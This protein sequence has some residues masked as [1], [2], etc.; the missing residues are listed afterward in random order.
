M[1]LT[2]KIVAALDE[3]L[4]L[5][6]RRQPP[7]A[8]ISPSA[9]G[10]ECDRMVS[11]EYFEAIEEKAK[12]KRQGEAYLAPRKFDPHM[13]RVFRDGSTLETMILD[14]LERAGFKLDRYDSEGKQHGFRAKFGNKTFSGRVDAI[15]V[16]SPFEEVATPAI[17]DVKTMNDDKWQKMVKHGLAKSH[18]QYVAQLQLYMGMMGLTNPA[19]LVAYNK[20][21]AQYAIEFVPFDQ[22][23]CQELIQRAQRLLDASSPYDLPRGGLSREMPPCT[24]CRFADKCWTPMLEERLDQVVPN[25]IKKK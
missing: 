14:D 23:K 4:D 19:M 9:L 20:N 12:A 15:I 11:F 22:E 24:W 1:T 5:E 21:T 10:G 16:R 17:V 18:P 3:A 13:H 6:M 8:A 2:E 7:W 25:W